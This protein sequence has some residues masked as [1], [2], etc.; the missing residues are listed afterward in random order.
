[1]AGGVLAGVGAL[2]GKKDLMKIGGLLALGSAA[3]NAASSAAGAAAGEGAASSVEAADAMRAA[4]HGI[5]N[6]TS[7]VEAPTLGT[8]GEAATAQPFMTPDALQTQTLG[9][10]QSGGAQ[11]LMQR[12]GEVAQQSGMAPAQ[13]I[14]QQLTGLT[15][16]APALDPVAQAGAGMDSSTMQSILGSAW[17]KTKTIAG[18]VGQFVKDN[19]ELVQLGSGMLQGMYGP[20]AE[21]MDWRRSIMARRLRNMNSPIRLTAT[22]GGM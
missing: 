11:S 3:V 7:A 2:T 21:Q 20:E 6:V 13:S 19:K 16:Q 5:G 18:G 9:A 4:E 15:Q 17:D 1:M 14:G 10:A 8:L 12:A 22:A